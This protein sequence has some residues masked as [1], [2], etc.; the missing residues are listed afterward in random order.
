MGLLILVVF[1]VMGTMAGCNKPATNASSAVAS[2]NVAGAIYTC[3]MHP[4]VQSNKP[5]QCPK[6]HMHLVKKG[7]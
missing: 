3:P 7:S 1:V 2:P 5:G 6:C 4:E